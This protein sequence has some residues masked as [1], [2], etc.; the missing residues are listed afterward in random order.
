MG[1]RTLPALVAR[2]RS[3]GLPDATPVVMV[4]KATWPQE[5]V[6][7]STLGLILARLEGETI[8][9]PSL[10]LIGASLAGVVQRHSVPERAK[11]NAPLPL[12]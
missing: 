11:V 4:E 8:S 9:G 5:R 12:P 6:I 7:G 10:F 1:V 3:G 2:L